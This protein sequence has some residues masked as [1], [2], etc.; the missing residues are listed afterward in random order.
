MKRNYYYTV[1]DDY[2]QDSPDNLTFKQLF[3][4]SD[5]KFQEWV[6][7]VR[8]RIRR[9]W[10]RNQIPPTLGTRSNQS[11]LGDLQRLST[12]DID[13]LSTVDDLTHRKDVIVGRGH[14][15]SSTNNFFPTMWMTVD[16]S[17]GLG[18][19]NI[20]LDKDKEE[21]CRRTFRRHFKRDGFRMYSTHA[22]KSDVK[23]VVSGTTGIEV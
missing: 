14:E 13:N 7:S 19:S 6:S 5:K 11:I 10:T 17:V 18:I 3:Y 23:S 22:K 21:I 9:N 8:K 12:K 15:G 16:T 1:E 2:L 20:L 4:S